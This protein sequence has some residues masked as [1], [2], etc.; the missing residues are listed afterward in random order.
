MIEAE[1]ARFLEGGCALIVGSV[2][3]EGQPHA[4]RG[5]GLDVLDPTTGRLRLLLPVEDATTIANLSAPDAAIAVTGAD[6]TSFRSVQ[7]KG[8]VESLEPGGPGDH[9]RAFRFYDRFFEDIHRTDGT[10]RQMT[11]LMIPSGYVVG[12]ILVDELFDQTPGPAAGAPL[13]D[14]PR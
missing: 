10:P 13:V 7:I 14:E 12:V 11:D 5:W 1:V 3:A 4:T 8:Q 6:V 9:E 2:D